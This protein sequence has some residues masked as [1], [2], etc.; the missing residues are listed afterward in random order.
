MLNIQDLEKSYGGQ[1]LFAG[2]SFQMSPRERLGLVGRNGH[3]KSTLFRIILGEDTPDDGLVRVPR[4][5]RI[6]HLDQHIH[7]TEPTVLAEACLGLTEEEQY[8]HYKAERILFGLGFAATD[9]DRAPGEF[10][11]G[12][13]VRLNLAKVLVSKPNLLLLDEPTNYLDIVSVRWI[14]RFLRG[15]ENELIIISHDRDFMDSVTTHT[16]AIHRGT[17]RRIEGNTGKLYA[18][19]AQ[20]EETHEKTR[21]NEEKQRKHVEAFVSRFRAK[22]SKASAV[23]SRVKQLEKMT[24]R[25]KLSTIADL[26]FR[27]H[28]APVASKIL[29]KA[30]DLA[31]HYD[32]RIPL[33]AHLTLTLKRNDRLAVI[34]KNGQ[35]K[36]TLLNLLAGELTPTTGDISTSPNLQLGYFGQTNIARLTPEMTVEDEIS[37]ANLEI[38]RTGVRS[39]CGSMMFSGKAA[40]KQIRVLSGGEKS[41]VLLGK[42]LAMPANLLLLDEPTNHLDMQSIESL[43]ESIQEFSGAVIMVTHS[44]MIL[45]QIA[46]KF[47]V[48]QHGRVEL[49][50]GTYDEF[51]EKVGWEEE[52]A[53]APAPVLTPTVQSSAAPTPSVQKKALRQA[54]A[55]IVARRSEVL[56]PLKAQIDTLEQEIIAHEA[57][58]KDA[59]AQLAEAAVTNDVEAFVRISKPLKETQTLIDKKFKQLETLTKKH[60]EKERRFDEQLAQSQGE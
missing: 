37:A 49:F 28:Y 11:G 46:T 25:E 57:A 6:G 13:Q 9:M 7:F 33:I 52:G 43:I 8:D 42:I 23:Q 5:Y 15:W 58:V 12:F 59:H 16:A 36:T 45:R 35:G 53:V 38:D 44:E 32:P 31:F 39:I 1:S 30:R 50:N 40:E 51:L 19:I 4:G 10:S 54:R 41:R 56:G 48:F 21:L 2:A 3:G 20:E 47:V 55:K 29:L 34:G 27:F 22:A 60:E 26:S 14:T 18:Q 17:I 24:S